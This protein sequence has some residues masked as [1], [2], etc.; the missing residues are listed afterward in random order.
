MFT[1]YSSY[2]KSVGGK[3]GEYNPFVMTKAEFNAF[4]NANKTD[5]QK[6]AELEQRLVDCQNAWY[7]A[8]MNGMDADA[9]H[10]LVNERN[11]YKALLNFEKKANL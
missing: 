1:S 6:H 9:D 5:E 3:A 2:L 4:K 7:N 11:A 8:K 10:A